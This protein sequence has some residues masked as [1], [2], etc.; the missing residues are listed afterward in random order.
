MLTQNE[1]RNTQKGR[2]L[3]LLVERGGAGVYVY[4]LCG[5]RPEGLGCSQYNARVLELRRMGH[6]IINDRPG[7]FVLVTQPEQLGMI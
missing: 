5:P 4:E 7:H 3:D 1:I 2:I 6:R